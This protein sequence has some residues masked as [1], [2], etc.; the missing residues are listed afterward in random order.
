MKGYVYKIENKIDGKVYIGKTL[1]YYEARILDHFQ[2]AYYGSSNVYFH[3]EI[4]KNKIED[5]E[6][7][8]L[9]I[10]QKETKEELNNELLKLEEENIKKYKSQSEGYN[11]FVTGRRTFIE[12]FGKISYSMNDI[13]PI[14]EYAI[15]RKISMYDTN[16][17]FIKTFN[18]LK[19]IEKEMGVTK[20]AV[21]SIIH[22]RK[23]YLKGY[24]YRW[25]DEEL[26]MSYFVDKKLIIKS[27]RDYGKAS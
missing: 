22:K 16:G 27:K 12:R 1:K 20:G 5:F 14:K 13:K 2:Q 19:D 10:V 7:E 4:R 11:T 21:S 25:E 26:D 17:T 9:H 8:C 24:I 18:K 3:Q 23:P 6:C 15:K